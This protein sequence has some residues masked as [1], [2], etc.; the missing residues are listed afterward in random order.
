MKKIMEAAEIELAV[1]ESFPRQLS[2]HA[3]GFT[4]SLGWS[5]PQLRPVFVQAPPDGIYDFDFLAEP[6]TGIVPQHS[7]RIDAGFVMRTFP[8][9]LKGVRIH[10]VVN[11]KTAL[12][13]GSVPP[14]FVN[15]VILGETS[16]VSPAIAS[17]GGRLYI[18]WKGGESDNLN[19]M[20]S[21]DNGATFGNKITS[22]ELSPQPPS[23]CAHNGNLYIS[24]R[25]DENDNL[26]VAR[27][28]IQAGIITGLTDKVILVE[29]SSASP[30]IASVDGRLYIAW[31]GDGSINLN[32]MYSDDNGAT[33]GNKI[34][35]PE[36]SPKP[37]SLCAHN[38][39]LYI[40][41]RGDGNDNLNVAQ[42][43]VSSPVT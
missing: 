8:E 21:D 30:A 1:L 18:A 36:W 15:K 14:T 28:N 2:I 16:S 32:V 26:N 37:P 4:S 31:K 20:Y 40:S 27:V 7:V 34:T 17:V 38:G 25:G 33:F 24:W 29:T 19:V 43:N 42:V 35:S 23:L 12:L 5:N 6:P 39:N 9:S 13:E 3:F 11:S 10:A 41:W 22:S